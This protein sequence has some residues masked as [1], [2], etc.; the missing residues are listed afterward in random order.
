MKWI[1][2]LLGILSNASASV[3]VKVAMTPPRRL[4][5]LS[6]PFSLMRNLPLIAGVVLYGI[7]FLL[8][9]LALTK[10]PL[11]VAHP[12]LTSGAIGMV[13]LFSHFFFHEAFSWNTLAGIAFVV[14]G[15][16]LITLKTAESPIV[17]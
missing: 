6:E 3:L 11:N 8:Y 1:I 13:A 5:T 14:V 10:L 15:V 16:A 7:A 2:L 12:I 17:Q 4:P 9:A